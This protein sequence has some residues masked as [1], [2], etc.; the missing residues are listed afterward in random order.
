MSQ[1]TA[2][3]L[4]LSPK[5]EKSWPA[6]LVKRHWNFPESVSTWLIGMIYRCFLPWMRRGGMSPGISKIGNTL[7]WKKDVL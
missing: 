2:V 4:Y 5:K 1:E 7:S 3:E 6:E